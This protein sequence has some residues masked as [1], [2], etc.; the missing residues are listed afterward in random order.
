MKNSNFSRSNGI[1][2]KAFT[3]IELL[4]VIA[5]IAIL[6]AIL[7]PVFARARENARKASCLSN[8]KQIGI[9]FAQYTQD[10][11]ENTVPLRVGNASS[12]SFSW[13]M[14]IEPYL[15]STQV[16]MCPS[17]KGQDSTGKDK[18]MTYSYNMNTA[19]AP[20]A[21]LS[22][23]ALPSQTVH[24]IDAEGANLASN[25]SLVFFIG[26]RDLTG[27]EQGRI[28][29]ANTVVPATG[30]GSCRQEAI[31]STTI[32]LGGMNYMFVDGHAKWLPYTLGGRSISCKP[33]PESH[34]VNG[35]EVGL[36]REGVIYFRDST[37]PGGATY[38]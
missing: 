38:N 3:L 9:A 34:K 35:A 27:N 22:S 5:I 4:V 1:F 7:F 31:S 17:N 11:D 12:L 33:I 21:N 26:Y 29:T 10:Y 23:F 6:A 32:H 20:L 16:F 14:C 15:K 19:G 36:H 24:I 2:I 30:A 37:E 8:L 25:Q 28:L 18:N 13:N